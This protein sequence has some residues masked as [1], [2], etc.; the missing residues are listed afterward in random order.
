MTQEVS[1]ATIAISAAVQAVFTLIIAVVTAVYV[2]STRRLLEI[3]IIPQIVVHSYPMPLETASF[4]IS[5]DAGCT[6]IDVMIGI[7]LYPAEAKRE[8][9][10]ARFWPILRPGQSAE[11]P[12]QQVFEEALASHATKVVLEL[13]YMRE[14]DRRAFFRTIE[15]DQDGDRRIHQKRYKG[16][17]ATFRAASLSA[18][19][20]RSEE[21]SRR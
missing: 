20:D 12:A 9:V 1:N 11:F 3:Q 4:R 19:R 18:A 16:F 6:I 14:A 15:Y 5:N 13:A 10:D 17:E 2:R 8:L 7:S 21:T